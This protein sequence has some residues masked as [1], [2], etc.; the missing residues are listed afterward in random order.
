MQ[1]AS[2]SRKRIRSPATVT[3]TVTASSSAAATDDANENHKHSK[4]ILEMASTMDEF[5]SYP[6]MYQPRTE[7]LSAETTNTTTNPTTNLITNATINPTPSSSSTSGISDTCQFGSIFDP[8]VLQCLKRNAFEAADH[9]IHAGASVNACNAKRLSPLILASQRGLFQ[10]CLLLLEKG[11]D[12]HHVTLQGTTAVLQAAHYG[13]LQL[14]TALLQAP[15]NRKL[16]ELANH[17]Q[18]TPLMRA[19][20]EGHGHICQWLL[21][22]GAL[23][24]RKN[25]QSMTALMLASQRGHAHVVKVL[26]DYGADVDART[27]HNSTALVLAVKRSN[28]RVVKVLVEHGAEIA[29]QDSKGRTPLYVAQYRLQNR[30]LANL[31]VPERQVELIQIKA[32]KKYVWQLVKTYTLLQ[33]QDIQHQQ[34]AYQQQQQ[35]QQPQPQDI[36]QQHQQR[37]MVRPGKENTLLAQLMDQLPL[38]IFQKVVEYVPFPCRW[39]ER[40]G[41]LTKRSMVDTVAAICGTCD[42]LDEVLEQG[43]FCTAC[44]EVEI[45]PPQHDGHCKTWVSTLQYCTV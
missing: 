32:R 11:A 37:A 6:M 26:I 13:H 40:I 8:P 7:W 28:T 45:A 14:L 20:Q 15:E 19:A 44:D 2:P 12:V 23:V 24:N 27:E 34:P 33:Q 41:M 9:L 16:M 17:H 5:M 4:R 18:T 3:V 21:Q 30:S 22:Q 1:A 25:H 36:L 43:G 10:M 42:V 35:Q 29:L 31:L 39:E 38:G